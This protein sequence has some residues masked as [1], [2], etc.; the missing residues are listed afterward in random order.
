M[1]PNTTGVIP[2]EYVDEATKFG[3]ALRQSFAD[4]VV[5]NTTSVPTPCASAELTVD[6]PAG[7]T[8]NAF[9]TRE[10]L[11]DATINGQ[12]IANYTIEVL[13]AS[14]GQWQPLPPVNENTNIGL[15]GITVGYRIV[16]FAPFSI[17]G[18]SVRVRCLASVQDP[19]L[20]RDFG[21]YLATPPQ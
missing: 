17:S 3:N 4:A 10:V 16:D 13:D 7:S 18:T 6:I 21:A 20:F 1:P 8:V 11:N 5:A 9:L 19:V 15:H 14:S 2:Q 12:R